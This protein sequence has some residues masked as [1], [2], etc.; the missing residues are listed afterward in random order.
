MGHPARRTGGKGAAGVRRVR[1]HGR[2]RKAACGAGLLPG[3][4]VEGPRQGAADGAVLPHGCPGAAG[5]GK[6]LRAAAGRFA[7][8]YPAGRAHRSPAG[9]PAGTA[10][11]RPFA[12]P[13]PRAGTGK[14][15]EQ[16]GQLHLLE[17]QL[18]AAVSGKQVPPAVAHL[19][20]VRLFCHPAPGGLCGRNGTGQG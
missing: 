4:C 16:R 3:A 2:L 1:R 20:A 10:A 8:A 11:Q 12:E 19:P 9:C 7:G 6:R 14:D 5:A 13:Q 17:G 18:A 15:P